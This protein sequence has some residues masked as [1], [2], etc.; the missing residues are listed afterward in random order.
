NRPAMVSVWMPEGSVLKYIA[1]NSP[2]SGYAISLASDLPCCVIE[3]MDWAAYRHCG[4]P[5]ISAFIQRYPRRSLRS[6]R[7]RR[8]RECDGDRLWAGGIHR[9]RVDGVIHSR[10]NT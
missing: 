5:G 10:R 2:V 3:L 6:E 9:E 8:Q 1:E 4:W 7:A